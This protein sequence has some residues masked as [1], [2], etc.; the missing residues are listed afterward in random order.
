VVQEVDQQGCHNGDTVATDD[1][2]Q[3][4]HPVIAGERCTG[5]PVT[6]DTFPKMCR[7]HAL[8]AKILTFGGIQG[9][10]LAVTRR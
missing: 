6:C 9:R 3:G 1:S 7:W 5:Q 10:I 8:R 4:T 2:A